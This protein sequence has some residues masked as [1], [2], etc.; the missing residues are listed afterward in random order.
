MAVSML[1]LLQVLS[2]VAL[3]LAI[4][5]PRYRFWGAVYLGFAGALLAVEAL[6]AG[7]TERTLAVTT[8]FAAFVGNQIEQK[9]FVLG[10]ERA[11]GF[12]WA[13][14]HAVACFA[15]AAWCVLRAPASG[16]E[17]RARPFGAPL[18]LVL[19]GMALVLAAEKL[20]APQPLVAPLPLERA[21]LPGT[22]AAAILLARSGR[23]LPATLGLLSIFVGLTR[24]PVAIFGT[25]ATRAHLGT[26]LD[27]HTVTF[28][29][30][31]LA[32]MPVETAA[33]STEQLAWLVWAPQL[34]VMPAVYMLSV[35]GVAFA[36]HMYA[37]H[38]RSRSRAA[39][40]SR[41]GPPQAPQPPDPPDPTG[42]P[43]PPAPPPPSRR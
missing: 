4:V 33:A 22:I 24:L 15:A 11:P 36:V 16:R 19:G 41:S 35:G 43:R 9:E 17:L 13:A 30:N 20:A 28:F 8:H 25:I 21:A 3:A 7:T 5:L 12:A 18:V 40:G 27:V 29:A 38:E 34:V 42:P 6:L 37:L 26:S 2:F 14:L 32:R 31:P 39:T 10:V 1:A 23:R